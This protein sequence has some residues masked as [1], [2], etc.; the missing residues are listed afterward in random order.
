MS[1]PENGNV[2]AGVTNKGVKERIVDIYV[3]AESL[4]VYDKPWMEG[5][6][7]GAAVDNEYAGM[8]YEITQCIIVFNTIT[9]L[10]T[11]CLYCIFVKTYTSTAV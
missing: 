7:K 3:S 10:N 1:R 2:S 8:R 11:K 5:D 6:S 4:F 9:Q